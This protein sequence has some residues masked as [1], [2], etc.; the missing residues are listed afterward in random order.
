M[1]TTETVLAN[2][3]FRMCTGSL[4]CCLPFEALPS[5]VGSL[6][7]EDKQYTKCNKCPVTNF[8]VHFSVSVKCLA[9]NGISTLSHYPQSQGPL[10]KREQKGFKIQRFQCTGAK[11]YFLDLTGM[12]H[13]L[14][15][16]SCG[17]LHNTS[18]GPSQAAFY[19]SIT[20]GKGRSSG[21]V[22]SPERSV[23][24]FLN[25]CGPWKANRALIN[26]PTSR[27]T[28][29]VQMGLSGFCHNRWNL[30]QRSTIGH[31]QRINPCGVLTSK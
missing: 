18:T 25:G 11:Q 4:V 2:D 1:L 13:S 15:Q 30:L 5:L 14:M 3:L 10:Q 7:V 29:K 12:L 31:M 27:S 16:S 23:L 24:S 8:D 28:Q 26:G 22:M 17:C 6:V 20:E 9:T 21:Q 19:Y